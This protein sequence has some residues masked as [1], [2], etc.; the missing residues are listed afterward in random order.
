MFDEEIKTFKDNLNYIAASL[1][2]NCDTGKLKTDLN[3]KNH[4]SGTNTNLICN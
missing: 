4:F 2:N 1:K 3:I